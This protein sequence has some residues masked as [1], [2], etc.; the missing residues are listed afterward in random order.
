MLKVKMFTFNDFSENTYVIH[1]DSNECIIIDPGCSF[2]NE[3]SMLTTYVSQNRLTP[4]MLIN[5]HCH[6]DHI[7]G[8]HFVSQKYDLPLT[9]HEGEQIVLDMGQRTADI[10]SINYTPSPDITQYLSEGDEVKFGSTKL[11]VYFTPGHSPASISLVCKAEKIAIVGD[12]LF[13]GSIGRTDLPGGNYDTLIDVIKTKLFALD[14]D[15][16]VYSG[17]GPA[18][19]I[20]KEIRTNPFFN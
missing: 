3:E 6:I 16:I 5:T 18:T 2:K 13:A 17:H 10:Y 9:A 11:E 8:N 19:S 12:V 7:L 1:D 20:G 15:T 4:V 14:P